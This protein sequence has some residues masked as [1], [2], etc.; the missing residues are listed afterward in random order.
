MKKTF[1]VALFSLI[2]WG[3]QA[4]EKSGL[5]LFLR[6]ETT[7]EWLIGLFDD[8]AIY[9]CQ[10][11]DYAKAGKGHWILTRDGQQKEV[12][13][14]KNSLTINSV[15][16]QTSVLT[17]EFLPD[18]PQKDTCR[19]F[20][21]TH[22]LADTVTFISWLKDMPQEIREKGDK[23]V[24]EVIGDIIP[25]RGSW[26]KRK[27]AA[28]VDSEGRFMIKVPMVNSA[29]VN[30]KW[31]NCNLH[32]V[33]EPGETYFLIHDYKNNRKMFMGKNCRLQNEMLAY[34]IKWEKVPFPEKD[35]DEAQTR[36]Y[37]QKEE[38]AKE[39]NIQELKKIIA[40]HP[41]ISNRYINF[42]TYY[43]ITQDGQIHEYAL[44]YT[45]DENIKKELFDHRLQF[46]EQQS[47]RP[48]TLFT[49]YTNFI[50]Y[51]QPYLMMGGNEINIKLGSKEYTVPHPTYKFLR[52]YKDAGKL[53]IT[54]EE[55]AIIET[56]DNTTKHTE[57]IVFPALKIFER[58]DVKKAL[59]DKEQYDYVTCKNHIIKERVHDQEL[60]DI[61]F[62]FDIYDR[63]ERTHL[64]L[65][66]IAMEYFLEN[67][68]TPV[69]KTSL[70]PSQEKYLALQSK[71]LTNNACLK[72]SDIVANLT[73]GEQILRKI[74]E[75]H[76]GKLVLLDFWGT[77][78][79]ACL[80]DLK[81]C[82][83]EYKRL[84][85]Y[86]VVFLYMAYNNSEDAW[87]AVIKEH[88]ILG[89]NVV[90]YNL[91]DAQQKAVQEYLKVKSFPTYKLFDR[92]GNLLD[93]NA[94]PRNLE[95]LARLLEK[96]K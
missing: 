44:S 84:K 25:I 81:H 35:M 58:E 75:P 49:D 86:D 52:R 57:E 16:H 63:I 70:I 3:G 62:A 93:V 50:K 27:N 32:T 13:L 1:I 73:D 88:N 4:K 33:F 60:R 23:A 7:G 29:Q 18:Y 91:P 83:E 71:E 48:Y 64:P 95:G 79:G 6:D 34:Q 78:C 15:K 24:V 11:W 39:E 67:V 14:K 12:R 28:K 68:T 80:E 89:K 26:Y 82:Q 21:D 92:E 94:S 53:Q 10:Y 38:S 85:D 66:E 59:K 40:A 47:P 87:K 56:F 41:N 17:S 31:G 22:Y 96:M 77:W 20:K 55:L 42:H 76:K 36:A 8:F 72:S 37:I 46:N 19:T 51:Q 69:A 43:G 54:D 90:H 74:L 5:D 65:P 2:A 9:D 45:K 61:F 30:V